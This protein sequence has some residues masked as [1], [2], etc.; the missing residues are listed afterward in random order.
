MFQLM[1]VDDEQAVLDG[2]SLTIP[3]GELGIEA[4]FK[5]TSAMEALELMEKHPMDIVVTDI[6]M[7][8][9][10]GLELIQEIRKRWTGT[11][12]IIL[13]GH[14]EFQYAQ[15][16][17]RA[18]TNDYLLKPTRVAELVKTVRSV[19][20]K[21]TY[22]W[23]QVSSYQQTL[24]TMREHLP[25]LRSNTLN[26]LLQGRYISGPD[27]ESKRELLDI[28]FGNGD[29][30]SLMLIRME[31]QFSDYD[32]NSLQLLEYAISNITE[33]VFGKHMHISYC[34]DSFDYLVFFMKLKEN[35][36]Q[37]SIQ[38][39]EAFHDK[40][41][42]Q[43]VERLAA[44]LQKNVLTY[45]KGNISLMVSKWGSFPGDVRPLYDA[46]VSSL[47]QRIGNDRG[48]F[49]TMGDEAEG[50][51][52]YCLDQLHSPPSLI[53]LLEAGR[54]DGAIHKLNGIFR[55]LNEKFCES[56]EHLL[57]VYYVV[58]SA[59]S[60]IAHKNGKPLSAIIGRDYQMAERGEDFF[61]IHQLQEWSLRVIK[62]L[63]DDIDNGIKHTRNSILV[64]VQEYAELHLAGDVSLQTIADHV[65]LHPVYLSKVYKLETGE[66]LSD[67]LYRLRMEKAAYLLKNSEE[68]IY[69]IARL[70]G[71][72]STYFMKVFKKHFGKTPQEFREG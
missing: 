43:L 66:A 35:G 40:G 61:S 44:Q 42:Q 15:E 6:R 23:E 70:V 53:H 14:A 59:C 52:I 41:K 55:E 30:F 11:K 22:E 45:L 1:I 57:E 48:F 60:N 62:R 13:S 7:P 56:R 25:L 33:E 46:A 51:E 64:Q 31:E 18:E 65:H 17:I 72:E 9:M 36:D 19:Q 21:L 69:E 50:H 12:C 38:D 29:E 8:G 71:Y 10:S 3:W 34:K 68:K 24:K 20:Q 58:C 67:Y 28:P 54:W 47:R 63:Q 26:D 27:L 37:P 39:E 16:A 49:F 5:A 2:L 32:P 4:V